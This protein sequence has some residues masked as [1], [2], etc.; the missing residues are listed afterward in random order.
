MLLIRNE[1]LHWN[2]QRFGE[3]QKQRKVAFAVPGFKLETSR[4]RDFALIGVGG[5]C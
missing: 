5:A 2:A 1:R 4:N 3:V